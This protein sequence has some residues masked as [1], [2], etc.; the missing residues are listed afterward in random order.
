MTY[1]QIINPAILVREVHLH[2]LHI[3]AL[4]IITC[5]MISNRAGH[6]L[7]VSVLVNA[8]WLPPNNSNAYGGIITDMSPGRPVLTC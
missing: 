4:P 2:S 1:L 7:G 8:M 5:S 3:Q 6:L